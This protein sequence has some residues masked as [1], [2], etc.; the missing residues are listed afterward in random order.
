[1]HH[2]WTVRKAG[3]QKQHQYHIKR[4]SIHYAAYKES[5]NLCFLAS[6]AFYTLP[7][8]D[9]FLKQMGL[10][11]M[12]QNDESPLVPLVSSM[13]TIVKSIDETYTKFDLHALP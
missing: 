7:S 11:S 1:M 13:D 6:L 10:E 3:K 4:H 5:F 9:A 8:R 2:T 12:P